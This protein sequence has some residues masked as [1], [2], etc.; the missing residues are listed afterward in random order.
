MAVKNLGRTSSGVTDKGASR[1]PGKLNIK[2]GP[3]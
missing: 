3:L 1:P 2:T